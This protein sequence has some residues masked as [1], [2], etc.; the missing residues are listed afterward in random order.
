MSASSQAIALP[1]IFGCLSLLIIVPVIKYVP[2]ALRYTAGPSHSSAPFI[3]VHVPKTGGISL[4]ELLSSPGGRDCLDLAHEGSRAHELKESQALAARKSPVVILREPLER[5]SSAFEFWRGGSEL[6]ELSKMRGPQE[7]LMLKQLAPQNMKFETFLDGLVNRSS[8]HA[9]RANTIVNMPRHL[10]GWAWSAHFANQT[11]WADVDSPN[12]TFV[13][14]DGRGLRERLRCAFGALRL[15]CNISKLGRRNSLPKPRGKLKKPPPALGSLPPQMRDLVRAHFAQDYELYERHCGG[16]TPRCRC[17]HRAAGAAGA[18]ASGGCDASLGRRLRGYRSV[19][20]AASSSAEQQ[21][22]RCPSDI[23]SAAAVPSAL[24][25]L[26]AES[27]MSAQPDGRSGPNAA[28]AFYRSQF[29]SGCERLLLVEDDLKQAG[30]GWTARYLHAALLLAQA[31]K[32]VLV[33]I[34]TARPRWCDKPP[35]TLQCLFAPWSPCAAPSAHPV[36]PPEAADTPMEAGWPRDAALVRLPLSRIKARS[37]PQHDSPASPAAY[38]LLLR[39]RA[40]VRELADCVMAER[41]LVPGRFISVHVRS[42]PEKAAELSRYGVTA[43]PAT[44]LHSLSLALGKRLQLRDLFVQ[45]ASPSALSAAMSFANASRYLVASFT[46]NQRSEHDS[47]GGWAGGSEMG[48]ATVA[49]VNLQIG[50]SAAAL[51]GPEGSL[52]T[53]LVVGRMKAATATRYVDCGGSL[54]TLAVTTAALANAPPNNASPPPALRNSRQQRQLRAVIGPLPLGAGCRWS[55]RAAWGRQQTAPMMQMTTTVTKWLKR[56]FGR[57]LADHNSPPSAVVLAGPHKTASTHLQLFIHNNRKKL[58]EHGWQWPA[59]PLLR[60]PASAKGLSVLAPALLNRRCTGRGGVTSSVAWWSA[61]SVVPKCH[62]EALEVAAYAAAS[63]ERLLDALA[64]DLANCT[65]DTHAVAACSRPLLASEELDVLGSDALSAKARRTAL[66]RLHSLLQGP[67]AKAAA[68]PAVVVVL[69]RPHVAHLRSGWAEW[70]A[71]TNS[72]GQPPLQAFVSKAE[73]WLRGTTSSTAFRA[74][75]CTQVGGASGNRSSRTVISRLPWF[76]PIGLA[77]TFAAAGFEGVVI[78][79]VGAQSAHRDVS[80][81]LSCDVLGVPCD[82]NGLAAWAAGRSKHEYTRS[83]AGDKAAALSPA[84]EA[85]L[86]AYLEARDCATLS[87]WDAAHPPRLLHASAL[88]EACA[89]RGHVTTA[90]AESLRHSFV[91]DHCRG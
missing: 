13:C 24:D 80:D 77:A 45:T 37:L 66:S 15:R 2:E 58:A 63:P 29:E 35:H 91:R 21:P 64:S 27:P 32:R 54:I 26:P 8:P 71:E 44:A 48:Q 76:D 53:G 3:F 5:L 42:S 74:F 79:S 88:L 81:V 69:R 67:S 55:S 61:A 34:P 36:T 12:T 31:D 86:E 30:L 89:K 4:R 75:A 59:A 39:P 56:T 60:R 10:S 68:T 28:K 17:C 25:Q 50:A 40:W 49:A 70:L 1:I 65:A 7:K 46:E 19:T 11:K 85:A 41:G 33:E 18:I 38:A 83:T 62:G 43:P 72:E 23:S 73:H 82:T 9:S 6:G 52:W 14:Y 22:A 90:A 57:R 78:D 84:A 16:C 47:W 51:I 87:E 20:P